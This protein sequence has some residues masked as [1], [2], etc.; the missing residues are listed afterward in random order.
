MIP[1]Y[2]ILYT[3]APQIY[4]VSKLQ[5]F[6]YMVLIVL[7]LSNINMHFSLVFNDFY[8]IKPH[9]SPYSTEISCSRFFYLSLR[10]SLIFL[11]WHTSSPKNF[12]ISY[13]SSTF[14][15]SL[16]SSLMYLP[17]GFNFKRRSSF[18]YKLA[19]NPYSL[20]LSAFWGLGWQMTIMYHHVSPR[21][22][23]W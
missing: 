14:Y 16:V 7:F 17:F 20:L 4:L 18:A 11:Q 2:S 15:A 19:S 8:F 13:V 5:D 21:S 10:S 12:L 3:S 22:T 9:M 23:S 6:N 1:F